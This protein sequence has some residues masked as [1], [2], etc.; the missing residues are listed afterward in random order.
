M[1]RDEERRVIDGV[2]AGNTQD[3]EIFVLQ[4][5]TPIYNL[6]LRMVG[7]EEDAYDLTQDAF[8]RAFNSLE[9]FRGDCKF[10]V[11][12]YRLTSNLCRDFLRARRRRKVVSLTYFTSD[13]G[14]ELEF[15]IPDERY[16]P[17]T[18]LERQELRD[19][20]H[21]GLS[22]LPDDQREIL[23]LREIG[24]MSYDEIALTLSLEPGT[25]KSRIFRARKKLC[26][27]LMRDGNFK[28]FQTSKKTKEV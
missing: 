21:R 15:E 17:H 23:L 14:E 9:S 11:W 16:C 22:R 6:A 5:Q 24:G 13:E 7:N 28:E 25:V 10:S 20:V 18:A 26:T 19:A 1:D 12:L 3:F 27:I 4:Y 2:L 8:I